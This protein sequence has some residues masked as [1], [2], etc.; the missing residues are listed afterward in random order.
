MKCDFADNNFVLSFK[1][2][3]DGDHI[4][5]VFRSTRNIAFSLTTLTLGATPKTLN[6]A[7]LLRKNQNNTIICL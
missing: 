5:I 2:T 1:Q 3:I 4:P 7:Y 6:H